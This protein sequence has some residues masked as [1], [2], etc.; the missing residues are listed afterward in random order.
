MGAKA[1]SVAASV[2]ELQVPVARDVKQSVALHAGHGLAHCR[3]ALP[4]PLGDAGTERD[5]ALFLQFVHRAE[6]HLG[7]ID[8]LAVVAHWCTIRVSVIPNGLLMRPRCRE[9]IALLA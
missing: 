7:R 8:E 1:A 9:F 6:V 5:D 2:A 3:P 4:E